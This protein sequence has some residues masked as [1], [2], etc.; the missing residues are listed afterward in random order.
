MNTYSIIIKI[1]TI[2]IFNLHIC[3]G[4]LFA[5][6]NAWKQLNDIEPR[7]LP[8]SCVLNDQIYLIGGL[9]S[10]FPDILATIDVY[11]TTTDQWNSQSN[12]PEPLWSG[13]TKAID[14]HIFFIGGFLSTGENCNKVF[15]FNP[16]NQEWLPR[17]NMPI[18]IAHSSFCSI[19]DIIYIFS[20]YQETEN[21]N[22]VDTLAFAY[23][24]TNDTWRKLK[25]MNAEHRNSIAEAI[26]DKIYLIGGHGFDH[27][28]ARINNTTEV[29]N[30]TN[31]TWTVLQEIPYKISSAVSTVHNNKIIVFGGDSAMI[32][33]SLYPTN[34]IQ[35]YDPEINQWFIRGT[36]PFKRSNAACVRINDYL[37]FFGGVNDTYTFFGDH[38][39]GEVW[40]CDLNK[41][42]DRTL[43]LKTTE[44]IYL[45]FSV[46]PNPIIQSAT[47]TYNLTR[48]SKVSLA[49]YNSIG[50]IIKTL[51][52]KDQKAGKY[53]ITWN[54][55][56]IEPGVYYCNLSNQYGS[57]AIRLIVIK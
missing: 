3:I 31:N 13:V 14:N 47:I 35:E 25:N 57:K 54:T 8:S 12:M 16:D 26:D 40:R 9:P 45:K 42:N 20:G 46:Y 1:I 52:N 5:Q 34:I 6:N 39:I 2:T 21:D 56:N 44:D 36:M 19:N 43:S 41:L 4:V 7:I 37:Y 29:Y 24:T 33:D 49:I 17:T 27:N 38:A 30:S 28:T 32:S 48:N 10:F 22:G 50:E 55:H 23:N 18:K 51:V 53:P 11:H 15:K